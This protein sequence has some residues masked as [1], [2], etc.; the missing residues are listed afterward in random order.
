MFVTTDNRTFS[1]VPMDV[2]SVQGELTAIQPK[3]NRDFLNK[4]YVSKGAY[5]IVSILNKED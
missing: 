1:S 5:E 3:N 4:K 2:L